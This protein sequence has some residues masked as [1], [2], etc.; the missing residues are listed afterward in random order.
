[1]FETM[2]ENYVQKETMSEKKL[3]TKFFIQIYCYTEVWCSYHVDVFLETS[4]LKEVC[5]LCPLSPQ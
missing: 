4:V 3:L 1:M 2:S 5:I